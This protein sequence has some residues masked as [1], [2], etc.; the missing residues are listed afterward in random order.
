MSLIQMPGGLS[1]A[2]LMV[3]LA[4]VGS[5]HFLLDAFVKNV[6]TRVSSDNDVQMCKL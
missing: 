3:R 4:L 6:L 1:S 2:A 5:S